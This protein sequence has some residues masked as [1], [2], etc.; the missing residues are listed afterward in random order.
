MNEVELINKQTVVSLEEGQLFRFVSKH[1]APLMIFRGYKRAPIT[2]AVALFEGR[3]SKRRYCLS[4]NE[5]FNTD[6][7]VYGRAY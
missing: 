5:A 6:V 1:N 2:G 3:N 4:M 7:H